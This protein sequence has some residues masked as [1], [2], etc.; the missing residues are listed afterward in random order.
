M[1]LFTFFVA[2]L[3]GCSSQ[4]NEN[5]YLATNGQLDLTEWNNEDTDTLIPLNG[6]WEF[7]WNQLL[8]PSDFQNKATINKTGDISL[9][10]KWHTYNNKDGVKQLPKE[11]FATYRLEVSIADSDEILGM[12]V[13]YMHGN[14]NLWVDNKLLAKNGQVGTNEDTSVPGKDPKVVYFLPEDATFTLTLQISNYYY[15]DGG[16]FLPIT[17]G[18]SEN[19]HDSHSRKIIIQSILLGV[20]ILAGIY[21]IV[22][23]V[24]RRTERYFFYFGA[25][26]LM[27][28][29]R[30]LMID[31]VLFTDMFPT[32]DWELTM[33]LEFINLYSHVPLLAMV[34]YSLYPTLNYKWFTYTCLIVAIVYDLLTIFT[35]AKI[36]HSFI[37]YFQLFMIIC[38]C[39]ALIIVIKSMKKKQQESYYIFTGMIIL[40]ATILLD[41]FRNILNLTE[42][43][44]YPIGTAIFIICFS[45]VLSKR[46]STSLDLSVEL[47]DELVQLNSDLETK[48]EQRTMQIQQSNRQLE[49]LNDKLKKMAL[50]DG[51]TNIPN[52]RQFDEYFEE[53]YNICSTE[54]RSLSLLFLDIDYFKK[55]ND[56]YG[57]QKGDECLKMVAKELNDHVT[58][59]PEGIVSR[60]GGEEFVC[61]LPSTTEGNPELFAQ[62][63]NH[64]I[65]HLQLPHEK[66]LVSNYV[67]V[68]IGLTTVIPSTTIERK[69]IIKQA[70]HALYQAKVAG[71]NRIAIYSDIN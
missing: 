5:D 69:D 6:M 1:I 7:Y 63:L 19:I 28:A 22:L 66:S 20:L 37:I 17:L 50:V 61:V 30:Y 35:E 45:L 10:S 64:R 47:S 68:S 48:V 18:E 70:D 57:H 56:Y 44:L 4:P 8:T 52:R 33:K 51:L 29:F 41:I 59:L 39:Y 2:L 55:Y 71:R 11:G 32:F 31:N 25:F 21:H 16:M 46:L 67:T 62:E 58:E 15:K 14:Y 27:V 43:N 60:Y 34:L 40:M 24:F 13:P 54:N 26:C 12:V 42:L 49:E 53:Q 3:Q 36:Y 23:G 9:P 65:E 38:V